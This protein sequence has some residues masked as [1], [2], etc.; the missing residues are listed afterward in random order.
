ML[1]TATPVQITKVDSTLQHALGTF[2]VVPA[3]V[4]ASGLSAGNQVWVYVFNDEASSAFAIGDIIVR[5]PSATTEKMYGGL[6]APVT[7]AA[8][9]LGVLGVAQHAIAAGSYGW[10]LCKGKG[11]CRAG[12]G[13]ITAD[14]AIVSGGS[15]AGEA[16]SGTTG[17]DDGCFI[18]FALEAETVEDATFDV[19]LNCPGAGF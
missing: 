3:R 19:Y 13:D 16:K 18:G 4:L 2:Q 11:L 14:A 6:I 7:N 1:T 8:Q 17:T 9:A 15:G 12:T 10:I 5:D